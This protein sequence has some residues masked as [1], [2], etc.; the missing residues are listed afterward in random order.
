M[1]NKTPHAVIGADGV[2]DWTRGEPREPLLTGVKT[3]F[4]FKKGVGDDKE[5]LRF[6]TRRGR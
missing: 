1:N 2:E 3:A 5:D 4:W 6:I